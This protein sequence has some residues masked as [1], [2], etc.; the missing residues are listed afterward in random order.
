MSA[1]L[2]RTIAFRSTALNT[3]TNTGGV[4][5]GCST[6]RFE[7]S[8]PELVQFIIKL[9]KDDGMDI[10][11][12]WQGARQI[13]LA[14]TVYDSTRGK[15]FDRIIA[16]E[17]I[18]LPASGGYGTYALTYYLAR[19]AGPGYIQKSITVRPNG[20]R[21]ATSIEMFGGADAQPL[22][23]PWTATFYAANPDIT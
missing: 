16:L 11:P 18:M 20:L 14:G 6:T 1:D 10:G 4:L 22:A 9:A 2:T 5:V 7:I 23:I 3:V 19:E 12:V 17:G 8:P 13:T 21:W 15:A